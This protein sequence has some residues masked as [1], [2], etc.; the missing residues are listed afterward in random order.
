MNGTDRILAVF[1]FGAICIGTAS[2]ALGVV[3]AEF[4]GG[5]LQLTISGGGDCVV[6]SSGG[7]VLANGGDPLVLGVPTPIAASSVV[8]L[9]VV[10]D[11]DPNTI[12]ASAVV[13][14]GGFASQPHIWLRGGGGNDDLVGSTELRT[15]FTPG[16]GDDT[17]QGGAGNDTYEWRDG[18][19]GDVVD[20]G[21]GFD[22]L[23]LYFDAPGQPNELSLFAVGAV[24][25]VESTVPTVDT[26]V[27]GSGIEVASVSLGEGDDSLTI[28]SVL[29]ALSATNL[30]VSPGPGTDIVNA[31]ACDQAVFYQVVYGEGD[32]TILGG[33]A[34]DTLYL[35]P[36]SSAPSVMHIAYS[37]SGSAMLQTESVTSTTVRACSGLETVVQSCGPS[38][39]FSTVG[40]LSG[41]AAQQFLFS[42]GGGADVLDASA[43]SAKITAWRHSGEIPQD[44]LI[45]GAST[46]DQLYVS[47]G[48]LLGPDQCTYAASGT[49]LIVSGNEPA[50]WQVTAQGFEST[51]VY[52]NSG[53]NT[54][55]FGD[56]AS[57]G[58]EFAAVTFG[59][60]DD[61]CNVLAAP[62]MAFDI[63]GSAHSS[64]DVLNIDLA[65]RTYSS[66]P[67]VASVTGC[68][69]IVWNTVENVNF[70]NPPS[71]L[72]AWRV[73]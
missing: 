19:E 56:L 55:T 23:Q 66:S 43:T 27:L 21:V 63:T 14:S 2:A 61:V 50:S 8:Q 9:W 67:G 16:P 68:A 44:S 51:F 34:N 69:P 3:D 37:A 38:G 30:I 20:L 60:G 65:G 59:S 15:Q 17:V 47:Q 39:S 26:L 29:S 7:N 24:V 71:A 13:A 73:Y 54:L 1:L 58:L 48:S 25:H 49:Q 18:A 52:G 33:T 31:S 72:D 5:I 64:G 6:T 12:D 28:G 41:T 32:D 36:N 53:S 10:G 40:D 46:D 4:S 42:L 22:E 70:L 11:S 57:T 35:D 45:A 62:T